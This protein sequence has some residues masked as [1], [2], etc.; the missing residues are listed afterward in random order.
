MQFFE[1]LY[2]N[3]SATTKSSRDSNDSNYV[4]GALAPFNFAEIRTIYPR[5]QSQVLLGNTG[6]AA[7]CCHG[8]A[9]GTSNGGIRR[10][11]SERSPRLERFRFLIHPS[12][13]SLWLH[14]NH[15]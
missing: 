3:C 5:T 13:I 7:H 6:L 8:F 12:T 9:K 15:G 11:G 2:K 1:S 4:G 10:L 14:E